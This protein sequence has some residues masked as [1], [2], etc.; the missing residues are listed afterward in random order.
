MCTMSYTLIGYFPEL[1]GAT[2]ARAALLQAG[3]SEANL[4]VRS[5]EAAAD[6]TR[7]NPAIV[8][9]RSNELREQPDDGPLGWLRGLFGSDDAED[10]A[11]ACARALERG[12]YLL[13]VDEVPERMAAEAADLIERHGAVDLDEFD[14]SKRPTPGEDRA[15]DGGDM[16]LPGVAGR[17]SSAGPE[18]IRT[19]IDQDFGHRELPEDDRYQLDAQGYPPLENADP[20]DLEKLL[21]RRRIKAIRRM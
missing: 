4:S 17:P 9:N 11:G 14:E 6:P 5:N 2:R 7:S 13:T 19:D 1:D 10:T 3:F 18:G 21:K 8:D 12:G 15:W 16:G 20:A